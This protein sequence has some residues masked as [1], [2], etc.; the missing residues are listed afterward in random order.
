MAV[1]QVAALSADVAR[2]HVP[3]GGAVGSLGER[4]GGRSHQGQEQPQ[5]DAEEGRRHVYTE[6]FSQDRFTLQTSILTLRGCDLQRVRAQIPVV[7]GSA[8]ERRNA[9]ESQQ[10]AAA[11]TFWLRVEGPGDVGGHRSGTCRTSGFIHTD[12][13]C[14]YYGSV[15]VTVTLFCSLKG[16]GESS[17]THSL[18]IIVQAA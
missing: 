4:P 6:N 18:R 13:V 17:S 12:V 9:S 16:F 15:N 8:A 10:R 5:P 7:S 1:L 14:P 11:V 3:T 2:N